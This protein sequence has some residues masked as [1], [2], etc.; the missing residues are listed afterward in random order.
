MPNWKSF[1]KEDTLEWLLEDNNHSVK[2]FTLTDLMGKRPNSYDVKAAK[3]RIMTKGECVGVAISNKTK[4][5]DGDILGRTGVGNEFPQ[6]Y[7]H[8]RGI[9]PLDLIDEF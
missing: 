8:F 7:V 5:G 3:A 4:A 6:I 9:N 1:L 2:Y